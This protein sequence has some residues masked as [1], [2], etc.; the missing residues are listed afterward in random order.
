MEKT[1][2]KKTFKDEDIERYLLKIC[3]EKEPEMIDICL[4]NL[5]RAFDSG[6]EA[7]LKELKLCMN[8]IVP[9]DQ[10]ITKEEI[11]RFFPS[12]SPKFSLD[13]CVKDYSPLFVG[14]CALVECQYK[15]TK[16]HYFEPNFRTGGYSRGYKKINL[17]IHD[18]GYPTKPREIDSQSNPLNEKHPLT[19]VGV[20]EVARL[21]EQR[22]GYAIWLVKFPLDTRRYIELV[23]DCS[24][25]S[26]P[27][28][29]KKI[30]SVF[31]FIGGQT[32]K[33]K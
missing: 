32:P 6:D 29:P 24:K 26:K 16:F 33:R 2:R 10:V 11:V 22:N 9:I 23:G 28:K 19:H 18:I 1:S 27:N 25:I 4:G 31:Y 20:L 8:P 7:E 3:K 5:R 21:S 15:G 12:P 17:A 30:V 14:N 13:V